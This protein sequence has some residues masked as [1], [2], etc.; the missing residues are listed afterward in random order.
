MKHYDTNLIIPHRF[1][2][3]DYFVNCRGGFILER[4][5]RLVK[6]KICNFE[7]EI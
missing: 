4:V 6:R 2:N 3:G 1:V 7:E 5:E